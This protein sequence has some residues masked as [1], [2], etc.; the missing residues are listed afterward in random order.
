MSGSRIDGYVA[1]L[2]AAFHVIDLMY[3]KD[4]C[5]YS[6][7]GVLAT[8]RLNAEIA[9]SSPTRGVKGLAV[10]PCV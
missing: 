3:L 6:G 9:C 8:D 5:R 4:M 1:V 10:F 7:R 2:Q